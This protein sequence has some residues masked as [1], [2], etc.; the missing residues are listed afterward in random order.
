MQG[1]W[2][3]SGDASSDTYGDASSDAVVIPVVMHMMTHMVMPVKASLPLR[4]EVKFIL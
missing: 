4:V 2:C 1:Q 3:R